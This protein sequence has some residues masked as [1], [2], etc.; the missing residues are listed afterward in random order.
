[1]NIG[2]MAWPFILAAVLLVV[3]SSG[4]LFKNRGK[5]AEDQ[6]KAVAK[7]DEKIAAQDEKIAG[8]NRKI[9]EQAKL[10]AAQDKSLAELISRKVD[11]I[12]TEPNTHKVDIN[13]SDMSLIQQMI[14]KQ[15]K[16]N[17]REV[18]MPKIGVV[19]I[20]KIFRDCKKSAKYRQEATSLR[21]QADAEL[22]KLDN[23]IKAQREGL[24]TL[25]RGSDSYMAQVKEIL[26]KQANLQAQQEFNKQ[27]RALK[28]QRITEEIYGDILRMTG[29]VAKQKG[30]AFVFERS[31]PKLPA[32]SPTELE[33]SMGM[34]KLLYSNG[35]IDISDEVMTRL[36]SEE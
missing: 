33:L 13:D 1:M 28:E 35:C 29:E 23:D 12:Q 20:R 26:K 27:Q 31:E 24:K 25:Q 14:E 18:N 3:L 10:L 9:A 5:T 34:H 11:R 22:V 17:V 21:Q 32:L 16:L 2:K 30:L 15:V 8:Q 7:Q 4:F 19:S 36:D 6:M